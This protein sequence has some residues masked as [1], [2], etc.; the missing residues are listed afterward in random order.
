VE[1]IKNN[2]NHNSDNYHADNNNAKD[3]AKH[4]FLDHIAAI[5]VEVVETNRKR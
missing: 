2:H 4:S 1:I 5:F 3:L